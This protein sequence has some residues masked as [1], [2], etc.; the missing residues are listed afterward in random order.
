MLVMAVIPR[1]QQER[2]LRTEK[3][4]SENILKMEKNPDLILL[5]ATA[6]SYLYIN[7]SHEILHAQY[8]SDP[9][10]EI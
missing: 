6:D 10:Y 7:F 4:F 8:F 3:E 2:R 9:A 1:Y 5:G